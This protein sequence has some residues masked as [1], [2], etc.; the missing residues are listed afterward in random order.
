MLHD[1]PRYG[2]DFDKPRK[3]KIDEEQ[4]DRRE[5]HGPKMFE[6]AE[7]R[8]L[9][10]NAKQPLKAMILLAI[11]GGFGNA[12][13]AA[14]P[15]SALDLEGGW[16]NFSRVKTRVR[17]RT[18]LWPETVAAIREWIPWRPKPKDKADADLLFVTRRGRRWVRLGDTG[19]PADDVSRAFDGLTRRLNMKRPGRSF[20]ALRHTFETVAG[21]TLDQI[22]VDV[23]MGHKVKGMAGEY[24]ERLGDPRLQ[25]V[26]E[27]VRQWLYAEAPDGPEKKNPR[28]CDPCDFATPGSKGRKTA[29]EESGSQGPQGAQNNGPDAGEPALRLYV[30]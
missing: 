19:A 13:L 27:H 17:R 26:A 22:A 20:Y 9:L 7:V 16:C 28:I 18:W 5:Q 24:I 10:G 30:G 11:N 14:L 3:T 8:A 12:D 29:E 6:A 21:E 25:A 4:N 23:C 2:V 15:L 1:P